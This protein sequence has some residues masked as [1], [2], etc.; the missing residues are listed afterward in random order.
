MCFVFWYLH[1]FSAIEHVSHGKALE[2]YAHDDCDDD[3][4]D[5]DDDGDDDDGDDDGDD[6]DDDDQDDDDD[7]DYI[8][9]HPLGAAGTLRPT[10][11]V[12]ITPGFCCWL[13]A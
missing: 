8:I 12:P 3:D 5:D 13:V 2:K 1:M 11:T 7:D 10:Y 4:D 9:T 6:E